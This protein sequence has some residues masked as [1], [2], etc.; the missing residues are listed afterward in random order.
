MISSYQEVPSQLWTRNSKWAIYPE[1]FIVVQDNS[2]IHTAQ[3]VQEWFEEDSE[4]E[5]LRWPAKSADL[6]PIETM[7]AASG[8][9]LNFMNAM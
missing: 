1:D 9:M 8:T 7:W 5:L 6:N 4:V 3:I 2:S